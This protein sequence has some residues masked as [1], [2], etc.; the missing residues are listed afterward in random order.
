MKRSIPTVCFA[1]IGINPL[2]WHASLVQGI[3]YEIAINKVKHNWSLITRS[4]LNKFVN[5]SVF[6]NYLN[7]EGKNIF[8]MPGIVIVDESQS[9]FGTIGSHW[10]SKNHTR[11]SS[12]PRLH[13]GHLGHSYTDI[14]FLAI[15]CLLFLIIFVFLLRLTIHFVKK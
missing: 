12:F 5:I 9:L 6:L 4:F 7:F 11:H 14:V 8:K 1:H 3:P 2:T 15:L 13:D 10:N